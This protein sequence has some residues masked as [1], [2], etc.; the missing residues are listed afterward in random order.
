[1]QYQTSSRSQLFLQVG[2]ACCLKPFSRSVS[3]TCKCEECKR[4]RRFFDDGN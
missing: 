3:A 4:D 2:T 1:M